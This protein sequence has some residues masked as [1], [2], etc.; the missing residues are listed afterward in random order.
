MGI[1]RLTVVGGI[2]VC[3]AHFT[4]RKVR[5]LTDAQEAGH[6]L[7]EDV[8]RIIADRSCSVLTLDIFDTVLWRRVPRPT[9]VFG[10]LGARLRAAGLCPEWVSDAMFRQMRVKAEAKARDREE[11]GT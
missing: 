4:P 6:P 1:V 5:T 7:L 2:T 3:D 8:H 10:I 11:L 9:D